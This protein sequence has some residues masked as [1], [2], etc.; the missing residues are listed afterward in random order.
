MKTGPV[1]KVMHLQKLACYYC[2]EAGRKNLLTPVS[3][4]S[5]LNKCYFKNDAV[6][7]EINKARCQK[8]RNGPTSECCFVCLFFFRLFVDC[9]EF[10]FVG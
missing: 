5:H 10:V 6:T 9:C 1:V 7:S 4:N 8:Y 2:A 3:L